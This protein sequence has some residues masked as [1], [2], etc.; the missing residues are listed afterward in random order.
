M[1]VMEFDFE[2]YIGENRNDLTF[3]NIISFL[4][5][6]ICMNAYFHKFADAFYCHGYLFALV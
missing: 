1:H 2:R 4:F 3:K 6:Y 5:I